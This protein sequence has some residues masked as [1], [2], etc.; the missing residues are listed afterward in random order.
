VR[1]YACVCLYVYMP[2][3]MPCACVRVFTCI[4]GMFCCGAIYSFF[5][6]F[7][8][9]HNPKY[10]CLKFLKIKCS[11]KVEMCFFQ[12]P[13]SLGVLSWL[14]FVIHSGF[15]TCLLVFHLCQRV[16]DGL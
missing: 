11:N 13:G 1:A 9:D 14:Y 10:V 4:S 3:C 15:P 16:R 6:S 5:L 8:K 7:F 2:V 12:S